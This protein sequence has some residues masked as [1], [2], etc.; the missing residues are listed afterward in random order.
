[1]AAIKPP[2]ATDVISTLQKTNFS[3][4]DSIIA[5]T[6]VLYV[7]QAPTLV[8]SSSDTHIV[9]IQPS[10][11]QLDIKDLDA[12]SNGPPTMDEGIF[13]RR[14]TKAGQE[15]T[16]LYTPYLVKLTTRLQAGKSKSSTP[17]I[18]LQLGKLVV[19]SPTL[20]PP[21]DRAA[22]NTSTP[23]Q[24]TNYV[25]VLNPVDRSVWVLFNYEP[26][27][28]IMDS[29]RDSLPVPLPGTTS[30]T[31]VLPDAPVGQMPVFDVAQLLPPASVQ[32]WAP[33]GSTPVL[34]TISEMVSSI[35]STCSM[36]GMEASYLLLTELAAGLS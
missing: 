32:K 23:W 8:L 4:E 16:Q 26:M 29:G 31:L 27:D 21:G 11:S 13:E 2:T 1:M 17:S 24:D 28:D 15:D 10:F 33:E 14:D 36:R 34:F 7:N 3:S 19:T 20:F 22:T 9:A 5:L 12:K 35:Q 25:A 30:P 18:G 6:N